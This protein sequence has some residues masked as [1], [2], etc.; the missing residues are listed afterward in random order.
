MKDGYPEQ[1]E[2][3]KIKNWDAIKDPHGCLEYVGQLWVY[4]DRFIKR[5]KADEFDKKRKVVEYYFST[6]GWSGNEDLIGAIMEN[7]YLGML[8]HT[9]WERGGHWWF[10]LMTKEEWDKSKIEK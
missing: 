3:D 8:F 5:E 6:G 1:E 7:E 10:E 4:P 9:R 2:L